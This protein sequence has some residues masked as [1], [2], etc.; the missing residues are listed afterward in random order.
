[1]KYWQQ[2]GYLHLLIGIAMAVRKEGK[3]RGLFCQ[4]IVY[5]SLLARF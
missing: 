5:A 3:R 2:H 1:V 4:K